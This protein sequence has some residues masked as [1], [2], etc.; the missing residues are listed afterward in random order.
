MVREL[1]YPHLSLSRLISWIEPDRRNQLLP[2][3]VHVGR[4]IAA[5][6]PRQEDVRFGSV[7]VFVRDGTEG[8]A[9][10][11]GSTGCHEVDGVAHLA[12]EL[13]IAVP[14]EESR[15]SC[16]DDHED[17][18]GTDHHRSRKRPATRRSTR[19]SR[20]GLIY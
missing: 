4:S 15:G 3:G 13:G 5:R 18:T 14:H 7:R 20:R 10:R 12:I 8:S 6:E 16:D 1:E 2:R 11:F 17:H 19:R 9:R